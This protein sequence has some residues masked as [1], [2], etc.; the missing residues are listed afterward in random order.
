MEKRATP[1]PGTPSE[2]DDDYWAKLTDDE[3]RKVIWTT[4]APLALANVQPRIPANLPDFIIELEYQLDRATDAPVPCAH[5]PH[6]QRHWHGFVLLA[7]DGS[8]YL[9]GSHCGPKAYASDYLVATNTRGR[10]RKR[11]EAL[12][13]WD[14]LRDRL[15]DILDA[16]SET[17]LDPNFAVVRRFRGAWVGQASGVRDAIARVKR[18]HL[19]GAAEMKVSRSIR[20]RPAESERERVFFDEAEKLANLPN[21]AHRAAVAELRERLGKGEIWRTD[22]GDFGTLQGAGWLIGS[23][24][25][26][27]LLD[28]AGRRLRGYHLVGATT[29]D[30]L[31]PQIERLIREARKDIEIIADQLGRIREAGQFFEPDHLKRLS[32]WAT[33]LFTDNTRRGITFSDSVLTVVE[34]YNEPQRMRLPATWDPPGSELLDLVKTRAPRAQ[35]IE[36]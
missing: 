7:S 35:V 34:G 12:L 30:K 9:L 15:L 5:C 3:L 19:T 14:S 18:N 33:A 26:F 25:P 10:A 6:H 29:T 36:S 8:R 16:L 17:S 4:D 1:S 11:S 24:N 2:A 23:E 13:A 22:E 31:T 28:D 32:A 20:D 21:K 27:G